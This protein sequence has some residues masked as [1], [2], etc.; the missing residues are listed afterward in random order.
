MST[1]PAPAIDMEN[2]A[3]AVRGSGCDEAA[4]RRERAIAPG[5]R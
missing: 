4:G 1:R 5:A 3:C 2:R